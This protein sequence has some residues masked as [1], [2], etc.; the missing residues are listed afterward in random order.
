MHLCIRE[1]LE[2]L[3]AGAVFVGPLPQGLGRLEDDRALW[4]VRLLEP[5]FWTRSDPRRQAMCLAKLLPL[6]RGLLLFFRGCTPPGRKRN[7]RIVCN[8]LVRI[9][10]EVHLAPICGLSIR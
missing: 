10:L 6:A 8:E 7:L 5:R 4:R 9:Y 1:L 2:K 3:V